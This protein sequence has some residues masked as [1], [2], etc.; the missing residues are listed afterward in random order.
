MIDISYDIDAEVAKL[1]RPTTIKVGRAVPV[2]I[3]FTAAPGAVSLIQLALGT[4]GASPQQLAYTE[5]FTQENATTWTALLDA[6]DTRL[7]TYMTG[8]GPTT[9]DVELI[10]TIDGEPQSPANVQITV[11]PSIIT[12]PTTSEGG[13]DYL[14]SAAGDA[15]YAQIGSLATKAD[16]QTSVIFL[17]TVTGYTGGGAA[18]LDGI[19]TAGLITSRVFFFKHATDGGR[20]YLLR[21]GTDAASSPGIIRPADFDSSTN[22]KVWESVL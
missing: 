9:I 22:A 18:N 21:D 8:K 14:T 7:V 5:T 13:P 10:F 2:R 19:A 1:V 17:P 20:L 15:R 6:S 4:D 12:G 16:V 11:Q 3:T